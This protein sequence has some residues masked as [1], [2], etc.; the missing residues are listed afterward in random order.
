MTPITALWWTAVHRGVQKNSCQARHEQ[1][2]PFGA[3][4]GSSLKRK[5]CPV[6]DETSDIAAFSPAVPTASFSSQDTDWSCQTPVGW[7][8]FRLEFLEVDLCSVRQQ[9]MRGYMGSSFDRSHT[10]TVYTIL[11]NFQ[12][13]CETLT[14]NNPKLWYCA[15]TMSG[16]KVKK[17]TTA[18]LF[19]EQHCRSKLFS[20]LPL[21]GWMHMCWHICIWLPSCEIHVKV[22]SLQLHFICDNIPRPSSR[23]W[24][25]H[26]PAGMD[27]SPPS[28]SA[29]ILSSSFPPFLQAIVFKDPVIFSE[30]KCLHVL[31]HWGLHSTP[32]HVLLWRVRGEILMT[33]EPPFIILYK[34]V[35]F[36]HL[37]GYLQWTENKSSWFVRS[38]T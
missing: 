4:Q 18:F 1:R 38:M 14:Q 25:A 30:N 7:K 15:T 34:G 12:E 3:V 22:K 35:C 27:E 29:V 16:N 9:S 10:Y 37:L 32:Q 11:F 23:D 20:T 17:R 21:W 5:C 28:S 36:T 24:T 2:R 26:P 33:Y 31:S 6:S 8:W 13:L 19:W